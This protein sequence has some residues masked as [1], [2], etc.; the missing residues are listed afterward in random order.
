MLTTDPKVRP[1]FWELLDI[2]KAP[3]QSNEVYLF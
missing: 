3:N 2:V 1:D